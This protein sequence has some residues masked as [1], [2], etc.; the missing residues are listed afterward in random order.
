MIGSGPNGLSAAI[1]LAQAGHSVIVYEA[2]QTIGGGTR[3]AELTLPGFVHDICS[4]V[5]PWAAGSP[6]FQQLELERSGVRWIYPEIALAH[7]FD[8]GSAAGVNGP[9]NQNAERFGADAAAIRKVLGPLVES[10]KDLSRELLGPLHLPKNPASMARFGWNAMQPA[11]KIAG[12]FSTRES[13]AV[14]AGMAAHSALPLD[15]RAT[16]GFGLVLWATCYSVGWPFAEGGS[17]AI[18]NALAARLRRLGG[19]IVTGTRIENLG[20]LPQAKAILCDTTPRQLLSIAGDK[21]SGSERHRFQKYR[22]G[23]GSFK[24]DWALDAPIPWKS[25]VCRHAG[26]L[27]LGG[28]FEEIAESESAASQGRHAEHPFVLLAQP[29]LFDPSRAPSGKHT[30]WGYCHVPNGSTFDMR[31]RIEAQIER[32]APGFRDRILARS[33]MFPRDLEAHDA[34]LVGG[35]ISGG[36]VQL[37]QLFFRPTR[38]LYST[39]VHNVFLCSSSTPPGP[40]VHGMCGHFSAKAALKKCF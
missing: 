2:E 5:H 15:W 24:I 29:S 4:C 8:D 37:D 26:T 7:P 25:E 3:S 13:R 1:T 38:R 20:D 12:K 22:Y 31:E 17:Q 10:W 9:F 32:F 30:A 18:A 16:A 21:I 39:P 27:H 19:E 34:N 33:V 23:P 35:D 36:S 11:A 28:T 6:F 14:L 40:G